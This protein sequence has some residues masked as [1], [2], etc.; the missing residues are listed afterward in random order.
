[1]LD[2]KLNLL[3]ASERR[4]T[5]YLPDK[6]LSFAEKRSDHMF[7]MD[8]S[9]QEWHSPRIRP[10]GAITL[11]PGTAVLHYAQEVFEGAKIFKHKDGE[12]YGFRLEE[13]AKRL[14]QSAEMLCMPTIPVND[15]LQAIEA[16]ADLDRLCYP[17]QEGACF[18]VRPFIFATEDF[19][20]VRPSKEYT[21]CAFL[22]PSGPYYPG[23]FNK[24]IKLFVT[25]RF[26]RASPGGTGKAKAGGNYASSLKAG[27]LAKEFG[28][29]QVLYTDVDNECIEETGAMNHYHVE[30]G[31]EIIIPEFTDTILESIT[32][33]SFLELEERLGHPVQQRK[34]RLEDFIMKVITK[35]VTEAGGLGTAA[36]VSPIGEYVFEGLGLRKVNEGEIGPVSRKMYDLLTGI[37]TGRYEAP[38][39][40]LKEIERRL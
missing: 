16:L 7:L 37:Q 36:V 14:N 1:M 19:L 13:N 22:S 38:E 6:V 12:L 28:A 34:V 4:T 35:K 25:S 24:T 29:S 18:Y 40:W 17:E 21:F 31:E 23:G 8:Y 27:E 10:Y 39:G 15:Q 3:P 9:D 20:G 11:M 2:I 33:K 32:T 26:K 30:N 5:L